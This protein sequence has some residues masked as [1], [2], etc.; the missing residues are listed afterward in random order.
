MNREP[1]NPYD[2]NAIQARNVMG[3]QIGHL[4]RT[5]ASKLAPYMV[6]ELE[7]HQNLHW[8]LTFYI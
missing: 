1:A 6:R 8:I 7:Y 5:I 3:E 4:P 2:Q